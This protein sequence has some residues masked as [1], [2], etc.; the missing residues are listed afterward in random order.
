MSTFGPDKLI[1]KILKNNWMVVNETV[2]ENSISPLTLKPS[3]PLPEVKIQ[4]VDKVKLIAFI[5]MAL[6]ANMLVLNILLSKS[7]QDLW[8]MLAA[9]QITIHM[10]LFKC[11]QTNPGNVYEFNG[12]LAQLN[13][14]DMY[15]TDEIF[16]FLFDFSET[17]SPIEHFESLGYEGSNFIQMT[18]SL[19]IN[20]AIAI[21]TALVMK[22]LNFMSVKCKRYP[23]MRRFGSKLK[24]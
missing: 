7:L 6:Q 8:G 12:N 15:P 11:Q 19:L 14:K 23:T 21:V 9:Q 22:F 13:Q 24:L 20:I 10:M 16:E 18:G 4:I 3:P 2:F 1:P 17:I 5:L